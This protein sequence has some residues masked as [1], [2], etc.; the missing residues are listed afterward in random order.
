MVQ[1]IQVILIPFLVFALTRVYLQAKRGTLSIG[2]GMFWGGLFT[3][4][5]VG[6]L[7]PFFFTY[8]ASLVGVGRGADLVIYFSLAL[9][10]YLIFRTSVYIEDLRNEITRLVRELSLLK[11]QIEKS[12]PKTKKNR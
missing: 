11:N 7:D 4:A 9:L 10:F 5:A 2:E 8:I 1:P 6:V 3:I 12:P